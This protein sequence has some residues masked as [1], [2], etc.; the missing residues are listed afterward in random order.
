MYRFTFLASCIA[1]LLIACQQ[2]VIVPD[3][4]VNKPS[5]AAVSDPLK[6]FAFTNTDVN[7]RNNMLVFK[8]S[9]VLYA[10]LK[11]LSD[12]R[13]NETC[14]EKALYYLG[15]TPDLAEAPT[16]PVLTLYER[17]FNGFKSC[18]R[19]TEAADELDQNSF[20]RKSQQGVTFSD[21]VFL[22][23]LNEEREVQVRDLIFRFV[24]EEHTIVISKENTEALEKVRRLKDWRHC[25]QIP[26]VSVLNVNLQEDQD[27][28][29]ALW[30]APPRGGDCTLNLVA[31]PTSNPLGAEAIDYL[32][33]DNNFRVNEGGLYDWEVTDATGEKLLNLKR[34]DNFTAGF[35]FIRSIHRYPLVVECTVRKEDCMD[36][37]RVVIQGDNINCCNF[38]VDVTK[39]IEA[40]G[41][42]RKF[43]F[44]L[45]SSGSCTPNAV[46][47]TF[48]G[49]NTKLGNS[50][51]HTFTTIGNGGNAEVKVHL[52]DPNG[53]GCTF[54]KTIKVPMNCGDHLADFSRT[55]Q[56][57]ETQRAKTVIW[58][59]NYWMYS[60]TGAMIKTQKK[61]ASGI[62]WQWTNF[63]LKIDY[64]PSAFFT[65]N[66][67]EQVYLYKDQEGKAIHQLEERHE[68]RGSGRAI[69]VERGTQ[70]LEFVVKRDQVPF[71]SFKFEL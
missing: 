64:S 22:T 52:D 51:E 67:C 53:S 69:R 29:M 60:S 71:G 66:L 49:Q 44:T 57:S 68:F 25:L 50:V 65:K 14:N 30:G 70:Y 32:L 54:S 62:G 8:D 21:P 56:L 26:H 27:R 37:K 33:M 19:L 55:I 6:A 12:L 7:H 23:I 2:E 34:I 3:A 47:W 10:V 36:Y 63:D 15:I 13:M 46:L 45:I 43:R 1:V 38:T 9:N 24:D 20:A 11:D 40:G 28:F 5:N 41:D 16:E 59:D 35:T 48:P 4:I 39:V 58:V 18:R 42:G 61:R 17:K 31:N